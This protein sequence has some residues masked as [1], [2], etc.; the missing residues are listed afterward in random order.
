MTLSM[1]GCSS[2]KTEESNKSSSESYVTRT[3]TDLA[4]R[5]VKIKEEVESVIAL[6][7]PWASIVYAIDGKADRIASFAETAKASYEECMFKVLAPELENADTRYIDDKGSATTFGTINM[8]ELAKLNPDVVLIYDTQIE[9]VETFEAAGIP[10]VVLKYGTQE[11][12]NEGIKLL[13]EILNQEERAEKIIKYQEET[14]SRISKISESIPQDEKPTVMTLVNRQLS[15]DMNNFDNTLIASAGGKNINT[16][17]VKTTKTGKSANNN[18]VSME[19]IMEWDPNIIL[20]SNFDTLTPDDL[21]NNKIEGQDW[22]ELSAVKNRR[23]YKIPQGIYRWCRP[24]TEAN[25]MVEWL[26]KVTNPTYFEDYNMK[27]EI[28]NYY[29]EIFD[30]NL[31]EKELDFILNTDINTNIKNVMGE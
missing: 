26:G 29:K 10:V 19:Q 27:E 22:S 23:V 11:L 12:A 17:N 7:W 28:S 25:L 6:P 14:I 24:S 3:I 16:E 31:S 5:K 21:Y 2:T 1:I 9:M 13:G 8:E 18:S 30:Y 15:V 4:G 20:L